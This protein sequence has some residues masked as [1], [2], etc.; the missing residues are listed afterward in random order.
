MIGKAAPPWHVAAMEQ[1][2]LKRSFAPNAVH[3]IRTVQMIHIQLSAMADQKASI[4]MGASF[5]IFTITINQSRGSL[6]PLPLLVLG[7]FAFVSAILTVL[8]IVPKTKVPEGMP[9]NLLFFGSF[10]QLQQ[11]DFID[12]VVD[13]MADEETMLRTIAADV[14]GNGQVLQRKK[15][16]YLEYAYRTFLAGL[17]A[18][19]AVFVAQA[20]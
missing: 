19:A 3:M 12:R 18:A 1:P 15:Y 13:S 10:T 4:L 11:D 7:A 6:P 5:V 20:L 17:V 9:V 14:Y 8:A 16:R 2:A